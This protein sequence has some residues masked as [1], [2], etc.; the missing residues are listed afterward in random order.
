MGLYE[1]IYEEYKRNGKTSKFIS[2]D[3][4]QIFLARFFVPTENRKDFEKNSARAVFASFLEDNDLNL[5]NTETVGDDIE[6]LFG[7]KDEAE[8]QKLLWTQ[9]NPTPG[10]T[11]D[12]FNIDQ[13][14][15]F[16]AHFYIHYYNEIKTLSSDPT[17]VER[18]YANLSDGPWIKIFYNK[19]FNKNPIS[20]FGSTVNRYR[21]FNLVINRLFFGMTDAV[22]DNEESFQYEAINNLYKEDFIANIPEEINRGWRLLNVFEPDLPEILENYFS[23]QHEDRAGS[24]VKRN[25]LYK[26]LANQQRAAEAG[27]EA[28]TLD[29]LTEE[30]LDEKSPLTYSIEQC[31]LLTGLPAFAEH[32]KKIRKQHI[33]KEGHPYG[34]R[35]IPVHPK[36]PKLFINYLNSPKNTNSYTRDATTDMNKRITYKFQISKIEQIDGQFYEKPLTFNQGHSEIKRIYLD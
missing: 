34:G 16:L 28:L 3:M 23:E 17:A 7:N 9:I 21:A 24:T 20:Y 14:I 18:F 26:K 11:W 12:R 25:A 29:E 33:A 22:L 27:I 8:E 30:L 5:I 31:I 4:K 15:G 10:K 2:N 36:E 1:D 19:T 6:R 35:V 13:K 32:R